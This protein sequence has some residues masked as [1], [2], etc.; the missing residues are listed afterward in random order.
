[1]SL[2]LK[3]TASNELSLLQ[4]LP[5]HGCKTIKIM[6]ERHNSN[7]FGNIIIKCPFPLQDCNREKK[8]G[9]CVEEINLFKPLGGYKKVS[10]DNDSETLL[11]LQLYLDV[12]VLWGSC[13]GST[14]GM[15]AEPLQALEAEAGLAACRDV[16]PTS[17]S[18]KKHFSPGHLQ[19]VCNQVTIKSAFWQRSSWE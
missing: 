7:W 9:T 17:Q 8:V 10:V 4:S 19:N 6:E 18:E 16:C 13:Q 11:V 2:T 14:E 15:F 5:P 1:M 12:W 3:F